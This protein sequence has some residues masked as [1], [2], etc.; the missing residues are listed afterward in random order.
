MKAIKI[1]KIRNNTIIM[2]FIT[3]IEFYVN[4]LEYYRY[5]E[6]QHG[7]IK[8]IDDQNGNHVLQRL[9]AG[10]SHD[11]KRRIARGLMNKL[12]ITYIDHVFQY[13]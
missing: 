6:V 9:I 8:F 2:V 3:Y 4:L 13:G 11:H 10:L 1:N 5:N 7:L 12:N